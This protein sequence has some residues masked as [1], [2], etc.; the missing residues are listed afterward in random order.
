MA[1]ARHATASKMLACAARHKLGEFGIELDAHGWAQ[2]VLRNLEAT[3]K[4]CGVQ[5]PGHPANGIASK[6][7]L[8]KDLTR[9]LPAS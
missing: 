6:V 4:R 9:R 5:L 3:L 8:L 2:T 1:D 7:V